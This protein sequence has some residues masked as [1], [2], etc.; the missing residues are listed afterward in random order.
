[1]SEVP[2]YT[3]YPL[4]KTHPLLYQQLLFLLPAYLA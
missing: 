4:A 3:V 2:L 1:M